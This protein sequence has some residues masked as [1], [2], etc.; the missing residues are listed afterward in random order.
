[1]VKTHIPQVRLRLK[2]RW[3]MRR[4]K[5]SQDYERLPTGLL[6]EGQDELIGEG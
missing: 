6:Q 5:N 2:A 3:N 1:M 4:A